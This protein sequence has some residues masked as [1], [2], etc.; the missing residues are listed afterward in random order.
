MQSRSQFWKIYA[1][2][3]GLGHLHRSLALGRAATSKGHSVQ[4]LTNSRFANHIPWKNELGNHGSVKVINH[5]DSLDRTKEKALRWIKEEGYDRLIIDTLPRGIGGELKGVLDSI[6]KKK[7]LVQ[8]DLNPDYMDTYKINE[9]V[10]KYNLIIVPGETD[11]TRS[12]QR[13]K[14]SHS[15]KP[16]LIRDCNEILGRVKA[17]S[18]LGM[19]L[20]D[21]RS[22]AIISCTGR[23]DEEHSFL[24]IKKELISSLPDWCFKVSSPIPGIGDISPWPLME[25]MNGI[26]MII[27]SGGYN[28]VNEIRAT[29]TPF[30]ARPLTRMYDRQSKRLKKTETY[31][32]IQKLKEALRATGTRSSCQDFQ[33]GAHKAVNLI[34]EE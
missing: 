13:M 21:K 26:D 5:K 31:T 11:Y 4:V 27:G 9:F 20:M 18:L 16:W 28:T 15:T 6:T 8:R 10:Q 23:S 32:S 14:Q 22:L 12:V 17:R 34:E 19:D 30:R 7:V 2:G 33:N 1:L 29:S 25:L 24:Q 3:G